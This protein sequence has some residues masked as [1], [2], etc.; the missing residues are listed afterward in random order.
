MNEDVA[1]VSL[2]FSNREMWAAHVPKKKVKVNTK[3]LNKFACG[4]DP[5]YQA[6]LAEA[7]IIG[8]S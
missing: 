8:P 1:R 3:D 6:I 2:I 5:T 4:V 7:P